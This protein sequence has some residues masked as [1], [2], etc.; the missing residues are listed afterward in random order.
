MCYIKVTMAKQIQ[1]NTYWD[2]LIKRVKINDYTTKI[3]NSE[4]W[5]E[6]CSI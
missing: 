6:H 2:I 4:N 1:K 3:Q 5:H